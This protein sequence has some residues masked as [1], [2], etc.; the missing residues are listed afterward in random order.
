M[1]ILKIISVLLTLLISI[2]AATVLKLG[3]LAPSGS[4]WDDALRKIAAEWSVLSQG[5]VVLKIYAGGI[6]GNEDDMI[7][8]MRIGQLDASAMTGIGMCRIFP[9]ILAIQFPLLVRT[10]AELAYVLDKMKPSFEK[11]LEAKGF[12]VLFWTMV[13]WAHFFSKNPVVKPE[14]LQKH[15]LFNYEGDAD[16]TQAWKESGFHPVP[17]AVSELMTSLQSGMT[18]AFTTTPLS[19][20]AYQWFGLAKNMCGM[21]WAPLIGGI[22]VSVKSWQK[23]PL[24]MQAKLI[25]ASR[26]IGAQMQNSIDKA[27]QSAITIMQQHGLVINP[28]SPQVEALWQE[29]TKKGFDMVVGKSFDRASFDEIKKHLDTFRAANKK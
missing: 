21:Q 24:D 19:A 20:A 29:A 5:T 2:N 17:L 6:A 22:V 14:D 16:G 18:D 26:T 12:K 3:S 23:I 1:K 10:D 7:R 28:V 8:K 27:D 13:G 11:E 9:G 15:K 25:Q 4:S